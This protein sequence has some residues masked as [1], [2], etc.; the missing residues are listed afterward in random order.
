MGVFKLQ[1][2]HIMC[3]DIHKHMNVTCQKHAG[4]ATKQLLFSCTRTAVVNVCY[5]YRET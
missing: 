2:K 3:N 1:A 5:M 4:S